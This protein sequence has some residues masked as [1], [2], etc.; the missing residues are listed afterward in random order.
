MSSRTDAT[1]RGREHPRRGTGIDRGRLAAPAGFATAVLPV[2]T[3]VAFLGDVLE[4]FG[5][6]GGEPA[7]SFVRTA[8]GSALAGVVVEV[9]VRAVA[10]VRALSTLPV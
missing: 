6:R 10:F 2:L 3:V 1:P 9:A 7:C 4:P 5:R 8:L